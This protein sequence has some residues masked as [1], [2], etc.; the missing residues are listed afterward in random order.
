MILALLLL[1][2]AVPDRVPVV[3]ETIVV[4]AGDWRAID[5]TLQ[6]RPAIVECAFRVVRG[7]SGVRL[8]LIPRDDLEHLQGGESHHVIAATAFERSGALRVRP[9]ALGEYALVVDNRMEGRTPAQVKLDVWLDFGALS[10]MPV[11]TLST[12]R[13]IAVIAVTLVLFGAVAVFA[14]RRLQRA[15]RLR[16]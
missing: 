15:V 4:P 1:L 5:L 8:A 13:R 7:K 2:A 6:Q 16:P 9:P 3:E 10:E 14:G 12:Q 11:R